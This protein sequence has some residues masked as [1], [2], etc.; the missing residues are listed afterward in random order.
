MADGKVYI[1]TKSSDFF[2]FKDAKTADKLYQT[3]MHGEI[4]IPCSIANGCLYIVAGK[5]LYVVQKKDQ[6][7]SQP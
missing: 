4:S 7:A 2:I 5:N 3:N 1:G 6:A